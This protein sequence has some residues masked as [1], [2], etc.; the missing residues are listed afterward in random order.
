ML[1]CQPLDLNGKT[2]RNRIVMPPM[3]TG[4]SENGAPTEELIRYYQ[5]RAGATA[6]I[7][8]EHAYIAPEGMASRGQLSMAE[9][10][11][12]PACRDLTAAVHDQ[13]ARILAQLNHAGGAAR[14]TG[15]PT[16]APSPITLR[17]GLPT[18]REMTEDD[19]RTVIRRFTE[20]ARRAKAVGFDGVEIHSA[21]GYLLNQFYSPL[22]NFRRDAYGGDSLE[23]RTRLH[24]EI[25]RS[26][27]QATGEDF[28]LALRFGACDY[29][30]GGSTMEEI[31]LA[32]RIFQDAGIDLLD[33]SGGHCFYTLKGDTRPGWFSPLSRAA[34][35][36]VSVPVLLTGGIQEARDAEALLADHAADLI[37]VGRSMIQNPHWAED[38]LQAL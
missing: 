35:Q 22:T 3:A 20:A 17:P 24:W 27:R 13:G 2:L 32:A 7:I 37:G 8:V 36:A 23:G 26:V 10:S 19:I 28:I 29:M 5:E 34:K 12:L 1:L 33:I 6:L 9:D 38:A 14:D 11:V 31:P 4:R 15:M 16:L 25:L 30:P 18:P 21:H